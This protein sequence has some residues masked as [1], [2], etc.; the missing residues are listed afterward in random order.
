MHAKKRLYVFIIHPSAADSTWSFDDKH[1]YNM[2]K[3]PDHK[4]GVT[5]VDT[6]LFANSTSLKPYLLAQTSSKASEKLQQQLQLFEMNNVIIT[7][8]NVNERNRPTRGS[9]V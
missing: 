6:C 4:F 1:V 2:I 3:D 5:S 8:R 7:V 9:C